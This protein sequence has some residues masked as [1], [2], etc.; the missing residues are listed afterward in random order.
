M[1]KFMLTLNANDIAEQIAGLL[2]G[3]HQLW[4]RQNNF[5]VARNNVRY[6]IELVGKK[7]VGVIGMEQFGNVTELKHLCVDPNYRGRGL[8]KKLLSKGIEFA[9]TDMV[10]GQVRSDNYV[11]IRNNLRL[12]MIPIGKKKK[13]GYSIIIFSRRK[14]RGSKISQS[15]S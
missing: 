3:S 2:N 5:T 4:Y 7:V 15:R 9:P 1:S 10:F 11:N 14:S 13:N 8:G 12:G 6:I